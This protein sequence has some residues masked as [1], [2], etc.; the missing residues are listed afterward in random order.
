MRKNLHQNGWPLISI[1]Q[2]NCFLFAAKPG[3]IAQ[4]N[5]G[6]SIVTTFLIEGWSFVIV[7]VRFRPHTFSF[8]H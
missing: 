1:V 5:P 8:S 3:H 6:L 4:V 2:C 7:V